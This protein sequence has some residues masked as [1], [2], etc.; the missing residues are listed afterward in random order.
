MSG[1]QL[2]NT[3][4]PV[5]MTVA[6]SESG[7]GAGIQ[8]DL[9]TFSAFGVYGTC[10]ITCL[11]AQTPSEVRRIEPVDPEMVQAQIR[12]VCDAFPVTAAK[13]GMLYS[14]EII[15]T[16]AQA[17]VNQ[18]IQLLVVDPVMVASSGQRLLQSDA[19]A[20]LVDELLPVARVVTPNLTEAEIILG[21]PISSPEELLMAA[22]EIATRYDVACIL[23]G[24]QLEGPTVLDVMVDGRDVEVFEYER[25]DVGETHGC[26]CAFSAALTACL[27]NGELMR[28]AV[29]LSIEYVRHA[30]ETAPSVGRHNPLNFLR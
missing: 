15:R 24:G 17:D 7:G 20:T 12:S 6:R 11:N 30:L 26:G 2:A 5:V 27:A 28:D 3:D 16:V 1:S 10:A 9:K 25:I 4:V 13:T 29:R 14:T 8:A 22:K 19:C 18:G 23:N 21:Q